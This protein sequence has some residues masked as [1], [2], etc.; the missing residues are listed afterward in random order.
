MC[1]PKQFFKWNF[2]TGISLLSK[3][4]MYI[5]DR[6][7]S[8]IVLTV[9]PFPEGNMTEESSAFFV[10]LSLIMPR[11]SELKPR[12]LRKIRAKS[13]KPKKKIWKWKTDLKPKK[14]IWNRKI[15]FETENM[16]C[17]TEKKYKSEKRK[18]IIYNLFKIIPELNLNFIQ[19]ERKIGTLIFSLNTWFY[20]F[21]VLTKT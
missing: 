20:F 7:H 14:K 18:F 5:V 19:T 6:K 21:Q 15:R 17:G 12:P 3:K 2:V 16:K 4:H 1:C 9:T 10:R 8:V 13:L 11:P